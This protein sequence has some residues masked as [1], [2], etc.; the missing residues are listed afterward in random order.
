M[1][2]TLMSNNRCEYTN[3]NFNEWQSERGIWHCVKWSTH[4][5]KNGF[6]ERTNRTTRET[7]RIMLHVRKLPLYLWG[8][9]VGCV[10][11]TQNRV[12]GTASLTT[13][14]SGWQKRKILIII[15]Y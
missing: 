9:A 15:F 13:P 1:A 10:L 2:T 11:Y 4:T 6:A 12:I 14:F 8:D 7:A 3:R 5:T